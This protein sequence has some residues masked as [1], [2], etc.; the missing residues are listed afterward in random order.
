MAMIRCIGVVDGLV[1][2]QFLKSILC[3]EVPWIL[4]YGL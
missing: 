1:R 3:H 2:N 4:F